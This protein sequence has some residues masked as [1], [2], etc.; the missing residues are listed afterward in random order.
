M[1]SVRQGPPGALPTELSLG[2][3]GASVWCV[4]RAPGDSKGRP[5]L[6]TWLLV[7]L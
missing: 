1:T 4:G 3:V 6:R 5:G 2:P 7:Y